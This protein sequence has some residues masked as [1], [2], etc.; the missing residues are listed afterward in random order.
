MVDDP[1]MKIHILA[2]VFHY[3]QALFEGVKAFQQADGQVRIFRDNMNFARINDGCD[4]LCMPMIPQD[5]FHNAIDDVIRANAEYIP[6]HSASGS[7]YVRPFVFGSGPAL[8]LG[9]SSQFSFI[10]LVAP[11]G[12]Y[13]KG[14]RMSALPAKI[15]IG[16]DRAAPKGVR[17]WWFWNENMKICFLKAA[18]F[19]Y[20]I[21]Y[22]I[23]MI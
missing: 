15:S 19:R 6:P 8:G 20:Q 16:Y 9:V 17:N 14:G 4:R 10:T 7:M 3:G 22:I 1:H 18:I 5:L 13:Y 11:V 21:Y 12:S 23:Y 2:N